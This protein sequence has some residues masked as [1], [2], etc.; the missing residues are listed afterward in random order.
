M[1]KRENSAY[2]WRMYL[3]KKCS[4]EKLIM[5]ALHRI[6]RLMDDRDIKTIGL[7]DALEVKSGVE[8]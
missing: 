8:Y 1:T 5:L 2:E 6:L 4:N 3:L 7:I